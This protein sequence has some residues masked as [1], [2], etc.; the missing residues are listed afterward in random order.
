MSK[1]ASLREAGQSYGQKSV[2]SDIPVQNVWHEAKKCPKIGQDFKTLQ[3]NFACF[4]TA[5]VKVYFLERRLGTRLRGH[6]NLM[7]F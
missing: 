4:L 5:I 6:P 2:C 7:F 1:K 3:S